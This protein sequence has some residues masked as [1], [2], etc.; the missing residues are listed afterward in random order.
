MVAQSQFHDLSQEVFVFDSGGFGG[1]GEVFVGGDLRVGV[2][3]KQIELAGGGEAEI[4]AGV[5][6]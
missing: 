6:G 5:A 1:V 2:G 3:F 4:E